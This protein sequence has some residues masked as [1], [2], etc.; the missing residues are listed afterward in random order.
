MFLQ[1]IELHLSHVWCTLGE[2]FPNA[3]NVYNDFHRPNDI[4]KQILVFRMHKNCQCYIVDWLTEW[5]K[6]LKTFSKT[7]FT[8]DVL[9][10]Q[11]F[12]M[13]V[14]MLHSSL[15]VLQLHGIHVICYVCMN[16]FTSGKWIWMYFFRLLTIQF[17]TYYE[18]IY[19]WSVHVHHSID[20]CMRG[21]RARSL[22]II[23]FSNAAGNCSM[24]R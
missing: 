16:G 13:D 2:T 11:K 7:K 21:S 6:S 9:M 3:S 14:L 23:R 22:T 10:L 17:C 4:L 8:M 15:V 20:T 12:T 5:R 19:T 1:A 24:N 18:Q